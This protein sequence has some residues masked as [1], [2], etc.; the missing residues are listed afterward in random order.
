MRIKLEPELNEYHYANILTFD[1]TDDAPKTGGKE[2]RKKAASFQTVSQLHKVG[3]G[4]LI[5][6]TTG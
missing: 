4:S 1:L 3:I 5:R 6:R 2:K